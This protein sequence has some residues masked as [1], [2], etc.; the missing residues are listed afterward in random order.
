MLSGH[1]TDHPF[2]RG[3]GTAAGFA[4]SLVAGPLAGRL[5]NRFVGNMLDRRYLT[6][7]YT[8]HPESVPTD[9]P[10]AQFRDINVSNPIAQLPGFGR[11][12]TPTAPGGFMG[13]QSGQPPGPSFLGGPAQGATLSGVQRV[14]Q[15]VPFYNPIVRDISTV[16]GI[17]NVGFRDQNGSMH[18]TG[19]VPNTGGGWAG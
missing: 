10:E 16:T 5:V 19:G 18:Y 1:G 2:Q 6:G 3:L 8:L 7:K 11:Q 15:T 4:T 14:Q 17:G 13:S 9:M 12:P